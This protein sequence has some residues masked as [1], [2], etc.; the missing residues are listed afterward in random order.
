MTSVRKFLNI[1]FDL[2]YRPTPSTVKKP[3][4]NIE[5]I[6]F[7]IIIVALAVLSWLLVNAID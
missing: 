6:N 1:L 4:S 3:L 5:L 2:C 7:G